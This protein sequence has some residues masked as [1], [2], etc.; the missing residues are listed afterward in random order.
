MPG[1]SPDAILEFW[2]GEAPHVSRN[3]WFSKDVAFDDAIRS[4]FG[5]AIAQA[6]A[7]GFGE[8]CH[9]PRGALAR[10]LLLDQFTRNIH[11]HSAAA[12]S[13]DV[14]ALATAAPSP[15]RLKVP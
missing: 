5:K 7:G 8:W 9:E 12:F 3:V 2:F 15:I 4:L 11:R 13:G 1:V 14:R 10:V 6:T